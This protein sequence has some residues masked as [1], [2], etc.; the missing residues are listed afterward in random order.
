MIISVEG[1]HDIHHNNIQHNDTQ[2]NGLIYIAL[3]IHDTRRKCHNLYHNAEWSYAECLI[4]FVVMLSD[5]M[6]NDVMPNVVA[7][8]RSAFSQK[9]IDS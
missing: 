6:L 5:N 3:S 8:C 4:S 7:P 2:H 1:R 9:Y